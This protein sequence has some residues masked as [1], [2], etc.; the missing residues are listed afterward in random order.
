MLHYY[1]CSFY[2]IHLCFIYLHS[3]LKNK[4]WNFLVAGDRMIK[5]RSTSALLQKAQSQLKGEKVSKTTEEEDDLNVRSLIN[6]RTIVMWGF[7]FTLYLCICID[8]LYCKLHEF[9]GTS[10]S[11][12]L[13]K[14]ICQWDIIFVTVNLMTF[15][16]FLL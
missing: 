10:I 8:I 15:E 14:Q 6:H 5:R 16:I 4:W 2:V 3:V 9:L 13:P 12:I 11:T 7:I 1:I